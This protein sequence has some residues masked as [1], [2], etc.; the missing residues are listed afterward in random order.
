MALYQTEAVVLGSKNWG[1]ADKMMT[2]FTKERGLVRA[3]AFGCRRPRSPLAGGTLSGRHRRG[4]TPE[5]SHRQQLWERRGMNRS[6][7]AGLVLFVLTFAVN[8]AARVVIE[9]RKAFTE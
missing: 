1:D 5:P 4:V 6:L 8:A 7:A 3:A 2:F 9:R